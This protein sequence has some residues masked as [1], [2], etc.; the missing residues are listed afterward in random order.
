MK[1]LIAYT[2]KHGTTKRCAEMLSDKLRGACEVTVLDMNAGEAGAPSEYDMVV[3]GSSVR[4]GRI[5]K[6]I[7]KYIKANIDSLKSMPCAVFLCCGFPDEFDEYIRTELPKGFVPSFDVYCF[8]GE[9]KPEKVKGVE[10]LLVK[11]IRNSITEH[12]FEDG[13]YK[14]MLPEILPEHISILA[15]KILNR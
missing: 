4:M 14:G 10:R 8:G 15:D 3:L 11:M 7:K 13:N 1:I 5:S 9:L 2:S 6:K 12:D